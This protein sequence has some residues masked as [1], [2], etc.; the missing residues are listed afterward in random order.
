MSLL[1]QPLHSITQWLRLLQ[2]GFMLG[3]DEY[4]L[5]YH[6]RVDR[7]RREDYYVYCGI[8]RWFCVT[9]L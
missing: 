1:E 4:K 8:C 3:S 2:H 6:M 9:V 7:Q 5:W